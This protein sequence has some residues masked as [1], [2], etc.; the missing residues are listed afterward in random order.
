MTRFNQEVRTVLEK[1]WMVS[2]FLALSACSGGESVDIGD[3]S[4]D[5]TGE[6]LS[7]YAATWEGYAEAFEFDS[8]SDAIRIVLDENGNGTLSVGNASSIAP[9]ADPDVGYPLGPNGERRPFPQGNLYSGFSYSVIGARVSEHRLRFEVQPTELF[10]A[11]CELQTPVAA[12]Y[13]FPPDRYFCAPDTTV[14][15]DDTEGCV[16]L[17]AQGNEVPI[18][19]NKVGLCFYDICVCDA[20]GC[21]SDTDGRESVTIDAA[22][23]SEGSELEGTLLI[24]DRVVVRM[25]RQ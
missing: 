23:A 25:S 6:K 22:L 1:R 16:Q 18:D 12:T 20:N 5:R 14:F 4:V 15:G 19:C 2:L 3:E 10:E 13:R 17:D 7:D 8:G 9:P 24:G 11:W 21:T